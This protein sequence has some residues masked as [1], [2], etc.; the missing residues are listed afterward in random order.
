MRAQTLLAL[1]A[2]STDTTHTV[3]AWKRRSSSLLKLWFGG[4]SKSDKLIGVK[5]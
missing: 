3:T 5:T 1:V 4:E 2:G